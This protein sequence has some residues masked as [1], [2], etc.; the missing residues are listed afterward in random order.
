MVIILFLVYHFFLT[1]YF[2]IGYFD[3]FFTTP[4]FLTSDLSSFAAFLPFLVF[5][6]PASGW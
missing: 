6:Y 3:V 5:N 4:Y 1:A 2:L